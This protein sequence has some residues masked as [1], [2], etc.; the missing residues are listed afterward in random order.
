[1]DTGSGLAYLG[2]R[3][4]AALVISLLVAVGLFVVVALVVVALVVG[5]LQPASEVLVSA[6]FRW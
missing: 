3:H 2:G 1:M 4:S 5:H 6:P